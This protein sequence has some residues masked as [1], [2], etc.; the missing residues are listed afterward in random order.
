MRW[1]HFDAFFSLL[2]YFCVGW[3]VFYRGRILSFVATVK[4]LTLPEMPSLA[5]MRVLHLGHNTFCLMS[6]ATEPA[7]H[8]LALPALNTPARAFIQWA[9][10][11]GKA[12]AN[13]EAAERLLR[14]RR[15]K[16]LTGKL[17]K[18]KYLRNIDLQFTLDF[19]FSLPFFTAYQLKVWN[20]WK[21]NTKILSL[22]CHNQNL[23]T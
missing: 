5:D 7:G 20:V 10:A 16:N 4:S 22:K 12:R 1:E 15:L 11:K 17:M 3:G 18:S 13:K 8:A 19:K 14:C 9:G 23:N 2:F 6:H 21:I